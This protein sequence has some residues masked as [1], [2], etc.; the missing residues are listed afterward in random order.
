MSAFLLLPL[1]AGTFASGPYVGLA[2]GLPL[3]LVF[4]AVC[5]AD[6]G[7][8]LPDAHEIPSFVRNRVE[9]TLQPQGPQ[10]DVTWTMSGPMPYVSKLICVFISMDR[11]VGPDFEAGLANL[12]T[13][14]EKRP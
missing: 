14:A 1:L 12:K 3:A 8:Q 10:T 6:Q 11:M 13:E 9:F 5:V 2:A 4:P 7:A